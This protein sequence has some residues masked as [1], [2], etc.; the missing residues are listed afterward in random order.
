MAYRE[1][2]DSAEIVWRAWATYPSVGKVLSKGFENGWITFE[3]QTE[4]RRLAPIPSGWEDFPDAKLALL[5]K[6]AAAARKK[7]GSE[8]PRIGSR[9]R[10]HDQSASE[11]Q[12]GHDLSDRKL[13]A[14]EESVT[15]KNLLSIHRVENAQRFKTR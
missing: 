15:D 4:C 8:I 5:L 2:V 13:A 14:E 10:Q 3:S 12:T 7:P 1:F 11:E 6:A 9:E